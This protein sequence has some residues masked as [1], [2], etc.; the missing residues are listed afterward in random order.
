MKMIIV[1]FII[2]MMKMTVMMIRMI[3]THPDKRPH[4]SFSLHP[5]AVDHEEQQHE[6]HH[7]VED[8]NEHCQPTAPQ[9]S[10]SA[11]KLRNISSK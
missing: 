10:A 5:L 1:I 4:H 9:N 6:E 8:E 11:E 2:V 7:E 3:S